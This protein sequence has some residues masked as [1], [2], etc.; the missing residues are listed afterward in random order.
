MEIARPG[1]GNDFSASETDTAEFGAEGVVIDSDFLDLVLGGDASLG[2]TV[3]HEHGIRACFTTRTGDLLEI[4][5]K[6]V[7]FVR[8]R[9][10]KVLFENR[11]LEA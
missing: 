5:H 6:I 11:C 8:Q 1:L 9:I 3:D 4:R 10:H 7:R 2:E